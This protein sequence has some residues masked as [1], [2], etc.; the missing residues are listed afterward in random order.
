[1][2]GRRMMSKRKNFIFTNKRHSDKAIMGMILGVISLFSLVTAV[3]LSYT[4]GGEVPAGYGFTGLFVTIFSVI[5]L[6]LGVTT[7]R[8]KD[9]FL[10]FP[11]VGTILN[12]LTLIMIG[13][14]LYAA[15]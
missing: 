8:Q 5:G 4:K 11:L 1:M 10:F 15:V 9:H 14:L 6:V 2:K 3:I 12:G 7:L 13:V